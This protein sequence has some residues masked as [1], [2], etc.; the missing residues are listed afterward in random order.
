MN[1]ELTI[2]A[3]AVPM[4]APAIEVPAPIDGT[5]EV[6][7]RL[8][9]ALALNLPSSTNVQEQLLQRMEH[10]VTASM[11]SDATL[12][13]TALNA[14][15]VKDHL[16]RVLR[17]Y[18]NSTQGVEAFRPFAEQAVEGANPTSVIY[19][20]VER[21]LRPG[22]TQLADL[23][24]AAKRAFRIHIDSL[25]EGLGPAASATYLL[26]TALTPFIEERIS[27]ALR[28]NAANITDIEERLKV[29]QQL[30]ESRSLYCSPLKIVIEDSQYARQQTVKLDPPA[31]RNAN[32]RLLRSLERHGLAADGNISYCG[33]NIS[34]DDLDFLMAEG[35]AD[36]P[37]F[38]NP[39]VRSST[40]VDL[41]AHVI[42]AI[43]A[44]PGVRLPGGPWTSAAMGFHI[45]RGTNLGRHLL[46]LGYRVDPGRKR[47]QR[48]DGVCSIEPAYLAFSM[49]DCSGDGHQ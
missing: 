39:W 40:E 36:P 48:L 14:Y 9:E 30:Q 20:A 32:P 28:D 18:L 37:S 26:Q 11:P 3:T 17:D 15:S 47:L 46:S 27:A 8:N 24:E 12:L 25:T 4:E 1:E 29:F 6:L 49:K 42:D 2:E 13:E 19:G 45:L 31:G 21:E 43:H 33:V 23:C 7:E 10:R 41:F 34:V 44:I 38:H 22:S 35:I 5:P 16:S